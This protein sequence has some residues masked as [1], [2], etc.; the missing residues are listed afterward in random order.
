VGVQFWYFYD[1]IAAAVIIVSMYI[2]YRRGIMKTVMMVVGF[3]VSFAVSWIVSPYIANSV[4]DNF[5]K[6]KN[7]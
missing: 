3:I 5:L 1:I 6:E 2:G 4:Y 7:N